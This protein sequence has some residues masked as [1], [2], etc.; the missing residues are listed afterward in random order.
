MATSK[1]TNDA[2]AAS[3]G[4]DETKKKSASVENTTVDKV[5]SEEKAP[6]AASATRA[7]K[8]RRSASASGAPRQLLPHPR[9]AERRRELVPPKGHRW[10]FRRSPARCTPRNQFRHASANVSNTTCRSSFPSA[11]EHRRVADGSNDYHRARHVPPFGDNGHNR[12][13]RRHVRVRTTHWPTGYAAPTAASSIRHPPPQRN[14]MWD[15]SHAAAKDVRHAE[16][17]PH[18]SV[19]DTAAAGRRPISPSDNSAP[20]PCPSTAPDRPD[21]RTAVRQV[22]GPAGEYRSN[23]A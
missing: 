23:A 12:K 18:D 22:A 7:N 19:Q 1:K 10:V 17:H 21:R 16:H 20:A 15:A 5:A 3:A 4:T 9:P 14:A 6:A 8:T 11:A 13:D 2:K